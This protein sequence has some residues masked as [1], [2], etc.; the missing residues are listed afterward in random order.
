MTVAAAAPQKRRRS[1]PVVLCT[2]NSLQF[3]VGCACAS[4]AHNAAGNIADRAGRFH[5]S[6]DWHLG[7]TRTTTGGSAPIAERVRRQSRA[8]C[9]RSRLSRRCRV[10]TYCRPIGPV[11]RLRRAPNCGAHTS[12]SESR[13]VQWDEFELEDVRSATRPTLHRW[14]RTPTGFYGCDQ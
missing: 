11:S 7:L 14:V 12:E 8:A 5:Y 10:A 9:S 1:R 3:T 6:L 13:S 2:T 4:N